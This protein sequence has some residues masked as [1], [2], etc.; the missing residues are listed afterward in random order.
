MTIGELRK[1]IEEELASAGIDT[2][3]NEAFIILDKTAGI[4]RAVYFAEPG[5]EVGKETADRVREVVARRKKREPLQY[6][7]RDC[8]FMGLSFYVDERVLI[9]RQDTECLVEEALSLMRQAESPRVLDLCCGSGCIG[10]S[11]ASLMPRAQVSLA[12]IS[13]DAINVASYN[14]RRLGLN[15]S[16]IQGDLFDKIRGTFDCILSNP[17]YIK[18][19]EISG[20]MAEVRDFE[21]VTALDGKADGLYFYREIISRASAYL[22]EGGWLMF[23][24]GYDQGQNVKT[25]MEENG[26]ERTQVRK[27]LSG[28]DRIVCGCRYKGGSNV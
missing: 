5:R 14:A 1:R 12:D 2:F 25:L 26:F 11:I 27:D 24:I 10:L 19:E 21:P 4:D 3:E 7:Y 28:L 15:V 9:P 6:I 13:Q 17:P 8:E 22:A 20:L 23:E 18:S 16:L